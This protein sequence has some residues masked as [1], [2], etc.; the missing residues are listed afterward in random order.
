MM[1]GRDESIPNQVQETDLTPDEL[2]RVMYVA[3]QI[4]LSR[5]QGGRVTQEMLIL[6]GR[7]LRRY[8]PRGVPDAPAPAAVSSS[9][10]QT[11]RAS[12]ADLPG[13]VICAPVE[14]ESSGVVEPSDDGEGTRRV[15]DL[16][17]TRA[18]NLDDATRR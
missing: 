17:L 1:I 5:P 6:M 2:E 10:D 15:G 18:I 7:A 13:G 14:E 11:R 12:I 16:G 9:D 3:D 8:M 4:V